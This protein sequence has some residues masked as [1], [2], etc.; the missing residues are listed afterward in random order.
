MCEVPEVF[1]RVGV[2]SGAL[3]S[4]IFYMKVGALG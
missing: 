3:L 2:F 4:S 1:F